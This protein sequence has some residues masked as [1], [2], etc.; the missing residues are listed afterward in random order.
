MKKFFPVLFIFFLLI[1]LFPNL[2]F[3][4]PGRTASD[5][6]HY[7]RTNCSKW[8]VPW[9]ARHCHGGY[10]APAPYSP[11]KAAAT[12]TEKPIAATP[13][14]T[15]KPTPTL[16]PT[17]EPTPETTPEVKGITTQETDSSSNII[18][19]TALGGL[20]WGGYKLLKKFKP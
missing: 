14:P 20:I 11:P 6:C 10:E 7:C 18:A 16:V 12:P 1:F 4:H 13:I 5:G 19:V 15:R 3:A 2:I 8:G 9:D 17:G